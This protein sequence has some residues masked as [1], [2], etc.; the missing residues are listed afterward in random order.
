MKTKTRQAAKRTSQDSQ[1]NKS[2]L[3]VPA[4]FWREWRRLLDRESQY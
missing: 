2:L 4:I 3:S 1:A